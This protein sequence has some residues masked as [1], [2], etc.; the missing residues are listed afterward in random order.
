MGT[1]NVTLDVLSNLTQA[2]IKGHLSLI[3]L[4]S[5]VPEYFERR[6]IGLLNTSGKML[7]IG[8]VE[9][10]DFH[11]DRLKIRCEAGTA[12]ETKNV[13]FGQY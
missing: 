3:N 12:S 6:L 11:V 9:A 5:E 7:A 1:S 13:Q 2:R 4:V 8:I 10:I